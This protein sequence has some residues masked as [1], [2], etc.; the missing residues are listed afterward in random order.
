ML[1]LRRKSGRDFLLSLSFLIGWSL[2]LAPVQPKSSG[3]SRFPVNILTSLA[4]P[5]YV[6]FRFVVKVTQGNGRGGV[7]RLAC[8]F[9]QHR[10]A[11][12]LLF[13]HVWSGELLAPAV[14]PPSLRP[15]VLLRV[16]F[17]E[18][19][20]HGLLSFTNQ[21]P[22]ATQW[23]WHSRWSSLTHTHTHHEKPCPLCGGYMRSP[24]PLASLNF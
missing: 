21:P 6:A 3:S 5:R 7:K 24:P 13:W 2:L 15:C 22:L 10:S 20:L 16:S 12:V 4:L 18:K 19:P 23:S 8:V 17:M 1:P 9:R 11:S 14:H